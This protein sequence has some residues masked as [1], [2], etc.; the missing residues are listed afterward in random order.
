MS[1][2][3]QFQVAPQTTLGRAFCECCGGSVQIR[4]NKNG[5]AYYY[6]GH[7]DDQGVQCCHSQRWG[8]RVSFA[9]RKAFREA[10]EQPLKVR[11]PLK[12]GNGKAPAVAN[13]D[14]APPANE[15]TAPPERPAQSLGGLFG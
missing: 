11:L 12:I 14:T 5:G 10:G 15:N 1:Y 6:C 7:A 3:G 2:N 8:Q 13:E 9:L 4:A